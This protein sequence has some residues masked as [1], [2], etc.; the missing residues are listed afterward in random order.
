MPLTMYQQ[1]SRLRPFAVTVKGQHCKENTEY[2][3]NPCKEVK[4]PNEKVTV[5]F[6][7][8]GSQYPGMLQQ[9]AES[10]SAQDLLRIA[11]ETL[12]MDIEEICSISADATAMQDTRIAQPIVFVADLMAAEM[13]RQKLAIDFSNV[14]AV[15]GFSLCELAALCFAGAITYTDALKLVKVRANAMAP[16]NGGAMCNL[17][18]VSRTEV[19]SL[20]HRF[21]C[22]IANI[23]C[24]HKHDVEKNVYVLAG[25]SKSID[26]LITALSKDVEET[27]IGPKAR[28]LRVSAAFHTDM[29][30][31]AQ[32]TF[33]RALESIDIK[34]PSQYLVYSNITGQPYKSVQEIRKL[35][36]LQIVSPCSGMTH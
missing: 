30:K 9:F 33:Q 11:S 24:D 25:T 13:M 29:M 8:Q 27:G 23:I 10:S 17:R 28:K 14:I 32:G 21:G 34:F 35:L 26:A 5:L 20:V 31:A 18:G 19:M 22:K 3:G 15:A 36:P 7:G 16:C 12:S 6:P 1:K 4:E 2:V